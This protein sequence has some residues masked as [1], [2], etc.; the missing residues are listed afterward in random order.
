MDPP[1]SSFSNSEMPVPTSESRNKQL[2]TLGDRLQAVTIIFMVTNIVLALLVAGKIIHHARTRKTSGSK[3]ELM[4]LPRFLLRKFCTND[5]EK[6]SRWIQWEIPTEDVFP[7]ILAIAI[8]IQSSTFLYAETRDIGGDM[9]MTGQC[10]KISQ[11]IWAGLF[12]T[13]LSTIYTR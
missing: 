2:T 8:S 10:E 6:L 1:L 13:P 12:P 5:E 7:L 9:G 3:N 4:N 11:L